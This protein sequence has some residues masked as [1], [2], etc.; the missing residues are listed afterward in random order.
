[1]SRKYPNQDKI[2]ALNKN[3]IKLKT[4]LEE[5]QNNLSI[6]EGKLTAKEKNCSSL[7]VQ[8]TEKKKE[9]DTLQQDVVSI[10]SKL[11]EAKNSLSD[12]ENKLSNQKKENNSSI[13]EK[14]LEI[15]NL[16]SEIVTKQKQLDKKETKAMARAFSTE[17]GE[18]KDNITLWIKLS[19]GGTV[20]LFI[21]TAFTVSVVLFSDI[22]TSE[23]VLISTV[24]LILFSFLFF[25]VKQY[26]FYT[27]LY[28]SS[29]NKQTL[30]QGYYNIMKSDED[31]Q[32]KQGYKDK[33]VD[34]ICTV[35]SIKNEKNLPQEKILSIMEALI[36]KLP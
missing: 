17:K 9:I 20:A 35:P 25:A 28:T 22:D 3:I 19:I 1:M 32:I 2:E 6:V 34:V 27:N 14:D 12:M 29:L 11:G 5:A 13:E 18:H 15:T 7:E 33:L 21:G 36:S 10:E 23:K 16:E 31:A 8:N 4:L 30:T 24:D 26:S